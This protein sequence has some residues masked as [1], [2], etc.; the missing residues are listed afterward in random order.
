[1]IELLYNDERGV[2][3]AAALARDAF[4]ISEEP[5]ALRPLILGTV[6]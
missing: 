2:P 1:V 3:E 4:T 5:P 6:R